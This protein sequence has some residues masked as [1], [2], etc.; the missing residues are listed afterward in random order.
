MRIFKN[1]SPQLPVQKKEFIQNLCRF[2][3][4]INLQMSLLKN[5]KLSN[6]NE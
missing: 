2:K 1:S 4:K 5:E 3:K 6:I